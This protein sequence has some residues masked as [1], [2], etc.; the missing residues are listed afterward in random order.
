M[1]CYI[2]NSCKDKEL[3][4]NFCKK[5]NCWQRCYE[6]HT[7][8]KM[9]VNEKIKTEENEIYEIWDGSLERKSS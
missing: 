5:E 8:C 7:E 3:C 6:D 9:F 4:C 1:K 2:N